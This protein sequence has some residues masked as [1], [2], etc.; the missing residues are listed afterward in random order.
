[1]Y[2]CPYCEEGIDEEEIIKVCGQFGHGDLVC[3]HCGKI[4]YA[5]SDYIT[6]DS[7]DYI[8]EKQEQK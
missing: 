8:L 6:E 3:Q 1:M 5:Y 2:D 4:C 7:W